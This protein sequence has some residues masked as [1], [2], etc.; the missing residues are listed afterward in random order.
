[1]ESRKVAL[2]RTI[3]IAGTLRFV[4]FALRD[5]RVTKCSVP[6]IPGILLPHLQIIV[7]FQLQ[8]DRRDI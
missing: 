2:T 1:M 8:A 3:L 7:V 5:E 6:R 4:V